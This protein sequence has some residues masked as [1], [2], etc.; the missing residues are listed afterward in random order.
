MEHLLAALRPASRDAS[1]APGP[2]LV[3][4][5]SRPPAP[6]R[7]RTAGG[8]LEPP[9][10]VWLIRWS[11]SCKLHTPQEESTNDTTHGT[12]TRPR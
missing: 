2:R 10:S 4:P 1:C 6:F 11:R 3:S 9:D 8:G 5:A 12:D 7:Q